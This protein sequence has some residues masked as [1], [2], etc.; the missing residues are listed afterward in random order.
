MMYEL[1]FRRPAERRLLKLARRNPKIAQAITDK[2]S[3]LMANLDELNHERMVG[4]NEYSLHVG[5]YRVL[6]TLDHENERIIVKD[7]GK[8]DEAY[9]R[10]SQ[11]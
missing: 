6:Y 3:W 11:R 1:E 4:H 9:R 2:I 10:L 7:M 8:H 5:Q